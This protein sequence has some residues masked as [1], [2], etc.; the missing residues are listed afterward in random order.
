MMT[1]KEVKKLETILAKIEKLQGHVESRTAR[2]R[3][4]RAKDELILLLHS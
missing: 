1:P 2:D 4:G 3:L